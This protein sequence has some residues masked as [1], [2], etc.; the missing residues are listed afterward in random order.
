MLIG[1]DKLDGTNYP[2][3]AYMMRHVLVAKQV[4][5]IVIGSDESPA[6]SSLGTIDANNA[7]GSIQQSTSSKLK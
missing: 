4:W 1:E 6:S 5:D 2:M 3:W 7:L